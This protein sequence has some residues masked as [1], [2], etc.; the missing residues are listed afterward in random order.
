MRH[1]LQTGNAHAKRPYRTRAHTR[2]VPDNC[3]HPTIAHIRQLLTPDNCS[4]RTIA[5]TGQLLTPDN[6]S[7]RTIAHTGQLLTPDNCSH[8]TIYHY[9]RIDKIKL[10]HVLEVVKTSGKSIAFATNISSS[11]HY[12]GNHGYLNN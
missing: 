7:H 11:A 1:F 8:R 6:C 5:H 3:S 9:I 2:H 4:H 12:F 10:P